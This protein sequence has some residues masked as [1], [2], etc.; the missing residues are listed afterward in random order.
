MSIILFFKQCGKVSAQNLAGSEGDT[1]FFPYPDKKQRQFS[2]F[3][4][5]NCLCLYFIL[6]AN[7][8]YF[9]LLLQRP[10]YPVRYSEDR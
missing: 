5:V 3:F 7:T 1:G 4:T 6:C 9:R 8:G 2:V 10:P